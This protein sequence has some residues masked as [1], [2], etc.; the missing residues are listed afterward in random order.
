MDGVKNTIGSSF[1]PSFG[2]IVDGISDLIVGNK[3]G[4]AAIA[5]GI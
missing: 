3:G 1:L 2:K 4:A 5:D